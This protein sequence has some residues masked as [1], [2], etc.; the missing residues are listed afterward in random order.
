MLAT[1][2]ANALAGGVASRQP[3]P[4]TSGRAAAPRRTH[5][6]VAVAAPAKEDALSL[7]QELEAERQRRAA[8]AGSAQAPRPTG[9]VVLESDDELKSTLEHRAWVYGGTALMAATLAQGL[10]H[11]SGP[12]DAAAAGAAA[13]AAYFLADVGTAFY[14]WGVDNYGDANTPVFGGQIAAFQGHHQRPWTITEREVCNNLF[15]LFRPATFF[16]AGLLGTAA[17]GAPV[18]W[19]VWSSS[20]LF[21]CCMSQQ[22]HAWSHM[23]KSEL[24]AA[25]VALQDAGLLISRKD[26]GAHHKAPFNEKYSIVSGWCN[27][28]LDGDCPENSVYMR[29]EKWI[30]AK[31]GVEPRGWFEPDYSWTEQERP[32]TTA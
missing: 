23:K 20:F 12:G 18:W 2:G 31:W 3:T 32:G 10:A 21:L 15:P 7:S 29:L 13:L 19:D 11:V 4:S 22:F 17:L 6:V 1:R 28:L 27:P 9:R 26:H 24:P 16:A 25:V 14:H 8:A 5:V 30:A